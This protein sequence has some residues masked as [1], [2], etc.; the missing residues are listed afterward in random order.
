[1]ACLFESGLDPLDFPAALGPFE[2]YLPM[3]VK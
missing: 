2:V 1:V 3:I